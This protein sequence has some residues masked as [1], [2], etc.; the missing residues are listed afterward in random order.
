MVP[1]V[2]AWIP[3][4]LHI[5]PPSGASAENFFGRTIS[6]CSALAT[7]HSMASPEL[8]LAGGVQ[9]LEQDPVYA[10]KVGIG[11]VSNQQLCQGLGPG[12]GHA[13]PVVDIQF[14]ASF[15]ETQ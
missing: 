15:E 13:L 2:A 6:S 7:Q 8:C 10:S 3:N 5:D 4:G 9:A 12:S 11:A 1:R 14:I